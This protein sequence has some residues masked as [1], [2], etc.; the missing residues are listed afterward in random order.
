[1]AGLGSSKIEHSHHDGFHQSPPV[2]PK[3]AGD[4]HEASS[5]ARRRALAR[6]R[7]PPGQDDRSP[8]PSPSNLLVDIPRFPTLP[9]TALLALQYLP[10]PVLVLSSFKTVILANEAMGRLLGLDAM[11]AL[12]GNGSERLAVTDVLRG[13]SLSQVGVDMVQGGQPIWVDWERFLDNLVEDLHKSCERS[14]EVTPTDMKPSSNEGSSSTHHRSSTKQIHGIR[15]SGSGDNYTTVHDMAVQVVLSPQPLNTTG[16]SSTARGRK[17]IESQVQANMIIS[18]WATEFERYFTLSFT[19]P[20]HDVGPTA[21]PQSRTVSRTPSYMPFSAGSGPPSTSSSSSA[22]STFTSPSGVPLPSSPFPLISNPSQA[23]IVATPSIL[24][25][26]TRMKDAIL[27]KM[28][29]PVFAMWR[30][31]SLT[32]PNR[33]GRALLPRDVDPLSKDGYDFISRFKLYTEDFKHEIPPDQYPLVRIC[34]E[35]KPIRNFR[36]GMIDPKSGRR[37]RYDFSG[38]PI[39]DEQKNE[40]L[41]AVVWMRDVTEYTDR[42]AAQDEE[43]EQQFQ[44]ICDTTPQMIWTSTPEGNTEYYSQR[45]YDYTG[46]SKEESIG[47]GWKA[48]FHPDDIPDNDEKWAHALATGETFMTESRCR[49]HDGVYRYML[50]R[51]L[52]LRHRKTGLVSKWIGTC[53]DIEEVVQ[54]RTEARD[55]REQLLNVIHHAQVSLWVVD[56][57]RTL[58]LLEGKLMWDPAEKD[59]GKDAIGKRVYDVFGHHAGRDDLELYRQPIEA[60]LNGEKKEHITEHHIDGNGRWF[61]TR[62]V[63][64]IRTEKDG[65]D[66]PKDSVEGVI[67]VSMDVTEL[68]NREAELV[69]QERENS[70]LIAKEAAAKEASRLKSQFLAN[71]SHEI[72]TP[73]AGV[74]GMSELLLDTPLDEEQRECAEN[75]ARS[76]NGLLTVINDILDF[77]KVESGRLDIEEVQFSLSVVLNDV[78]KMLQFAAER[79][80]LAFESEYNIGRTKDLKVMGDPGRVRQILTNLL[81][82]SIK[83]TSEGRV[84]LAVTVQNETDD[85]IEVKFLVEDTGIGIEED[86]RKRLFKPFSQ[87]D[88]S[89]ARRFGG[90]GLGLTICKNVS[91]LPQLHKVYRLTLEQLVDLMHGNITLESALGSGTKATFVIPFN[92]PQ[93]EGDDSPLVDIGSIPERLQS[94][95]SVS[96][97]SSDYEFARD[98]TPPQSPI[99]IIGQS[100]PEK[101][102]LKALAPQS[103][104]TSSSAADSDADLPEHERKKTHVLVVEDNAINQQIA[105]KTIKK[106]GFSVSAVWNGQQAL[107][108]L[109]KEPSEGHPRPAIILMDVQMPILDG[110][111]ATHVIRHHEPFTKIIGLQSVPIVAMTA[112]AIQGDMEKCKKAGMDDYLAKPVKGKML[113]RMLV[114]WV[115]EGR[116]KNRVP[117]KYGSEEHDSNCSEPER[118]SPIEQEKMQ[119]LLPG[120]SP[121]R[122]KGTP[123]KKHLQDGNTTSEDDRNREY[124]RTAT[125]PGP[126]SEGERHLRR[127]R[128]EEKA[129]ALRDNKLLAAS[130]GSFYSSPPSSVGDSSTAVPLTEENMGKLASEQGRSHHAHHLSNSSLE[131]T[132]GRGP[133]SP[134]STIGSLVSPR[135]RLDHG[136]F[137]R[138]E[139][140][141]DYSQR[142]VTPGQQGSP[143]SPRSP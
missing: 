91:L 101:S 98:N 102:P 23:T 134:A 66:S 9:E 51:A 56:T 55:L 132:I 137:E 116:K 105:L 45:W 31:E 88:S 37:M 1:M 85:V 27:N 129:T 109:A 33:A 128:A 73:I 62:F 131:M 135:P 52:P 15:P 99:Q 117:K 118:I 96:C 6:P 30:D 125:L 47:I 53:T 7:T 142:T 77:S 20:S 39:M 43:M 111:R 38:E 110:Y 108:Y 19:S 76:A 141:S 136:L 16:P 49:R 57:N 61:R 69:N 139:H 126:E 2:D 75:I 79:K 103:T 81:T 93:Y 90:T 59:I 35:V 42:I 104:A 84:K 28:E 17:L 124:A 8:L 83:F 121:G 65:S 60:I 92:K 67:G 82:N 78:N 46:L 120:K 140:Q 71:M 58:S 86:V 100:R 21:P 26:I 133:S 29:I 18:L 122:P 40:Y 138:R 114:K 13:Q 74:I 5:L 44:T 12:G 106:L 3:A 119:T 143:Q 72:R 70:R 112:S 115:L 32:L 123:L 87:A 25:K 41:A 4:A 48:A 36:A 127:V 54:A 14:E 113:E 80:D 130:A 11:G 94:E 63:P 95:L 50:C 34:R 22:S 64:V 24:Q 97:S 107:D 10:T 89:T 68:R